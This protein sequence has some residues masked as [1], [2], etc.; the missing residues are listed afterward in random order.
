MTYATDAL[1]AVPFSGPSAVNEA[2]A[3]STGINAYPASFST[4]QFGSPTSNIPNAHGFASGFKVTQFG[5][6]SGSQGY[7]ATT[8]NARTYSDSALTKFGTP[9]LRLS[10]V[11]AGSM[12]TRLGTP[13]A[14]TNSH[15]ATA[16]GFQ[17]TLFGTPAGTRVVRA[18][19]SGFALTHF[20]APSIHMTQLGQ[21][22]GFSTTQ[23]GYPSRPAPLVNH[24]IY[25]KT[26]LKPVYV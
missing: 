25:V 16:Q 22:T 17:H 15:T 10:R 6:A 26:A 14:Y 8:I 9:T 18:Y 2:A 3:S 5:T 4:T 23:F 24:I 20:G 7:T 21:A 12:G 11:A 1:G 13:T 19:P